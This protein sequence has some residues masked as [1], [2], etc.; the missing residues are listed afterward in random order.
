MAPTYGDIE[1]KPKPMTILQLLARERESSGKRD[2][3]VRDIMAETGMARGSVHNYIHGTLS[4]ADL[5]HVT[6]SEPQSGA[7]SDANRWAITDSGYEWLQGLTTDD[8]APIEASGEAVKRADRA[9]EIA[10]EARSIAEEAEERY[11]PLNDYAHQLERGFEDAHRDLMSD[12]EDLD[13]DLN[14]ADEQIDA[15]NE[16][17]EKL[18]NEARRA[19]VTARRAGRADQT[20]YRELRRLDID[21]DR[22]YGHRQEL[23]RR[24]RR[25]TWIATGAVI[26][27]I[28]VIVVAAL[29]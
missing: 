4:P 18:R 27:A 29:L 26:L 6:G 19:H 13:N 25:L 17:I 3:L 16:Q 8:L 15:L 9:I 10:G 23:E 1:I 22:A 21:L 24:I 12:V 11:G 2:V 14:T 20:V 7:A 5:V 28:G